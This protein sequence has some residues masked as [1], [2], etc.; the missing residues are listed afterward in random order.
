MIKIR[1]VVNEQVDTHLPVSVP[2]NIPGDNRAGAS[3]Q[4]SRKTGRRN[5]VIRVQQLN[6]ISTVLESLWCE[7]QGHMSLV[8]GAIHIAPLF[9]AG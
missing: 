7:I 5:P 3:Q 4:F 1:G 6:H 8:Y 2:G 9:L